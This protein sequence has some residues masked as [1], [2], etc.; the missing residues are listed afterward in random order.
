MQC[1]D[2]IWW[3][4]KKRPVAAFPSLKKTSVKLA[5]T[6]FFSDAAVDLLRNHRSLLQQM[7][8]EN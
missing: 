3:A 8:D 4:N 7:R 2:D 6:K 1:R 5:Q